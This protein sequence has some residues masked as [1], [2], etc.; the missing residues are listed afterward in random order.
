MAGRRRL[1]TMSDLKRYMQS[2]INRLEDG[3]LDPA[4]AGRLGYLVNIM[5][6]VIQDGDFEERLS[7]LES[8]IEVGR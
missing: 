1:A 5:R 6:A 7:K 3:D 8:Q 4:L 2:V